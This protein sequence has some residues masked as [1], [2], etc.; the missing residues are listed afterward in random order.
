MGNKRYRYI[1][2][3]V[4]SWRLGRSLGID[5]VYKGKG[6]IC[7]FDCVYCQV[8]PTSTLTP[9]RKIFVPTDEIIKEIKSL[10]PVS[11][12][13]ITFS[14]A[15]EPT[16][17]KNLGDIV[18]K[19]RNL[20]KE[21]IAILTNS[22]IIKRTDVQRDLMLMDFVIAKLDAC[23]QEM[24]NDINRPAGVVKFPELLD[25]LGKFRKK[26]KGEFALQIMF[27]GRNS[28]YAKKIA[29][30]A[31]SVKPNV[32]QINTPI[33][34]SGEKPL[35]KKEMTKIKNIFRVTVGESINV[36]NVF[37]A[38]KKKAEPISEKATLRRRG[39]PN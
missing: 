6:K 20:R 14:G 21:K 7:S 1:Y 25:G 39:K 10:P 4:S 2:G 16:L 19:I 27:V 35:S 30:M 28:K 26:F 13:Y 38:K 3:P 15:C 12:D 22:S 11:I 31:R 33:R 9:E 32:I 37:D 5:P 18:K 17:A 34:P 23:S 36:Q 8:G 29:E 24:L